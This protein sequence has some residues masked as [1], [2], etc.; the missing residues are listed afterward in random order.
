MEIF[1]RQ[2]FLK[3]K[4]GGKVKGKAASSVQETKSRKDKMNLDK[5]FS[6]NK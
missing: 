6:N 1:H 5:D 4:L 3:I 2:E